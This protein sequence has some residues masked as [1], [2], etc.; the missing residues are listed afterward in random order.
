[1]FWCEFASTLGSTA[2]QSPPLFRSLEGLVTAPTSRSYICVRCDKCRV[3]FVWVLRRSLSS[4]VVRC[5]WA[6]PRERE[7]KKGGGGRQQ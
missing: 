6:R 1:M 4:T 7:Q 3:Q 5:G 2:Q